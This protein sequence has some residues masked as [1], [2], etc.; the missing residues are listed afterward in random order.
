MRQRVRSTAALSL[1]VALGAC[2]SLCTQAVAAGTVSRLPASAYSVRAVCAPASFAHAT[3]EA[4]ELVARTAQARAYDHP[5]GVA[6]AAQ[7][8]VRSARAG[9]FGLTPEDL[10][11]AYVL[12]WDAEG[13]STQTIALVDAYNDLT[14]E[15]DLEAYDKEFGLPQCTKANGC[16]GKVNQNGNG[17]ASKLPFPRTAQELEAKSK[18]STPEREEA[19]EAD[20]WTVEISL[21]IETA[22]AVCQSCH[23]VLVEADSSSDVD[24]EA[25]ENAAATLGAEEISNSWGGPECVE[26]ECVPESPAFVHPGIVITASAGDD[27]YRNWLEEES[28]PSA[29][30]PAS[31]PQVVAVGGTSLDLGPEA[32]WAGESVWNDGGETAGRP[33]GYGASGGGCSIQ[34]PAQPWQRRVSDWSTV[35]CGEQRAVADVAAD[36]DPY[37]GLAVHDSNAACETDGVHWCTIGGTSLASPLIASTFALAGGA[38]GVDYPARTLYENAVG[39]PTSLHDVREGSNGECDKEFEELEEEHG[40]SGCTAA[41]EAARSCGSAPIC[42]AGTGYDG[43]SGVGTPDGLEAFELPAGGVSEEPA[44]SH[45]KG[46]G[47]APSGSG[48]K[49]A[50]T[51]GNY[52]E[53]IDGSSGNPTGSFRFPLVPTSP[54]ATTTTAVTSSIR[55]STLAL[56][57]KAVV[58]LDTSHPKIAQIGFTFEINIPAR[59]RVSLAKRVGKRRRAHW[60]SVA[61]SLTIAAVSG[62][63]RGRLSGRGALRPGAYRLTITPTKGAARSIVFQIGRR[64][65]RRPRLGP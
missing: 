5:L 3:C 40:V 53:G 56:T 19:Q 8:S 26:G 27:G 2:W 47:E 39:S 21:D 29:N 34:F 7:P 38:G 15:E 22:R 13:G 4:S 65:A 57:L 32:E 37:S 17:E 24:L 14:A 36:A 48:E 58:A 51:G 25:A 33:D 61:R 30:F 55:L 50:G 63:N 11:A 20:G 18:G 43:P 12:P 49:G 31:L 23:I 46:E 6:L 41:E 60:R 59:V 62:R 64:G 16:F 1:A 35:G 28:A 9:D 54:V 45:E 42:V 52:P 44:G 10:H